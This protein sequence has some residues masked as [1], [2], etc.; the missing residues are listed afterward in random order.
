L[1]DRLALVLA[2]GFGAGL[3]PFAPGTAGTV[4]AIPLA[5]VAGSLATLPYLVVCAAVTGVA[6]WAADR[7]DRL[8]RTH[9]SGRIVIDEIAGYL[10][11]MAWVD[12]ADLVLL[13][14]GFF[15]FRLADIVKPAPARWLERR[16]PGGAGVVLDDVAAGLWASV[17]VA[18]MALTDLSGHLRA[19]WSP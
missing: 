16:V 11:T 18:G 7:A 19:I 2:T 12:R 13:V 15:V 3:S 8:M 5:F 9:D 6:I 1:L 14:A 10:V 17:V 4:V